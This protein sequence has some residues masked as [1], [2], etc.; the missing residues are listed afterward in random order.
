MSQYIIVIC[1]RGLKNNTL[2]GFIHR[3]K[4][5]TTLFGVKKKTVHRKNCLIVVFV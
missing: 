4:V 3:L 2:N 1:S 5:L